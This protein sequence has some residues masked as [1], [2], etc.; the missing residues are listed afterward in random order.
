[1]GGEMGPDPS[2]DKASV[3]A[4]RLGLELGMNFIDTA[5]MYGGGHS[6]EVVAEAIEGR[7]EEVFVA[8][9]VSPRHFAHDDVLRSARMSLKR[10]NRKQM[11]LYQPRMATECGLGTDIGD[12]RYRVG[13][14]HRLCNIYPIARHR[15]K[16]LLGIGVLFAGALGIARY[17]GQEFFPAVDAGQIT[18]QVRAP[19]NL[20]LDAN[21][22]RIIEANP[23]HRNG[24]DWL[25]DYFGAAAGAA[26]CGAPPAAPTPSTASAAFSRAAAEL[27]LYLFWPFTSVTCASV[28]PRSF[29]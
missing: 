4:I 20:R 1:M 29:R 23:T 27:V 11:D 25:F 13:P 17:I 19:S 26:P 12:G 15:F 28:T 10:L 18:I 24:W 5:E 22:R 3:E 21:E 2:K 6:E 14:H 9:K 16:V 8:S 7:R